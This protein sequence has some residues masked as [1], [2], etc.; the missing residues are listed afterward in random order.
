MRFLFLACL[1]P[2]TGNYATAE[3]IRDHI[4]SAGH[5]C[6]LRDTRDFNSASEVKLLMSQ[7]PQ[8]FDAAL[9]IHLFKGG[10]LSLR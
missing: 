4:E 7:D 1:I 6:V 8:P 10:R 5:V 3:R 9:S 2:K